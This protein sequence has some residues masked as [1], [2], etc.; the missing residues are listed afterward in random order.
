MGPSTNANCCALWRWYSE[1]WVAV[2]GAYLQAHHRQ[3]ERSPSAAYFDNDTSATLS[4]LLRLAHTTTP[5]CHNLG[6][7]GPVY[8]PQSEH[9]APKRQWVPGNTRLSQKTF[10]VCK[11]QHQF[12]FG[13]SVR[14]VCTKG[15]SLCMM[16]PERRCT[17]LTCSSRREPE[18]VMLLVFVA[19]CG[20]S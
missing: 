6:T 9:T 10:P 5:L 16:L 17:P 15:H 4:N 13:A 18:H 14:N 12:R 11:T 2:F 20:S 3:H 19:P 7:F 8:A 1:C